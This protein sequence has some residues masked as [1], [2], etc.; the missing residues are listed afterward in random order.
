MQVTYKWLSKELQVHVNIAKQILWEFYEKHRENSDIKCTYL[1]MGTLNN[2][3]GMRVEV[4]KEA[5]LSKAKEK[6]SKIIS[7]HLYSVHRHLEDLELLAGPDTSGDV[8]YSAIKCDACIERT[9]EEMHLLRWRTSS[10]KITEEKAANSKPMEYTNNRKIDN[11]TAVT[12]KNGFNNFFNTAGKQKSPETSKTEKD[13]EP[14]KNSKDTDLTDKHRGPKKNKS[15]LE[16]RKSSSESSKSKK[17]SP[18]TEEAKK[19]K[20]GGLDNFFGK[21]SSLPK[22]A[23]VKAPEKRED[24]EAKE[25]TKKESK[26]EIKE[27]NKKVK[28]KEK[29]RGKKRVRSQG[30]DN[31]A[32]K[33]K[34]IMIQSD[35]SDSEAE[36]DMD[37]EEP[38]P[39]AVIEAEAPARPKSPSPPPVKRENGK[40]KVL[41]MVNETYKDD[42]GFMVTKKVHVYVSCSEDEEE[43]QER[44]KREKGP[45]LS[46]K[47]QA[48]VDNTKKKQTTLMKFFKAS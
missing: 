27:E 15:L 3:N 9:D 14:E 1:L 45:S 17:V 40:R 21:M 28:E 43:E 2:T 31:A 39:E 30:S 16:K 23:E 48:K 25:E 34:R 22:P 7:Q 11:P 46:K 12:K 38:M 6:Y 42:R 29:P 44:K 32:K 13:Q 35:S 5:D 4:V 33:R 8:K 10:M 26:K 24:Q 47:A 41:K 19:A 20:K 36:N 18:K 37:M